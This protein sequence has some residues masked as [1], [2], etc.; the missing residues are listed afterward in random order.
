MKQIILNYLVIFILPFLLG[1]VLRFALR[2]RTKAGLMTAAAALLS[3]AAWTVARNPPVLGSELY[4]LRFFQAA[5]FTTGSLLIG[6]L[7]R[8]RSATDTEK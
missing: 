4:G 8:W 1:G 3:L 5:C 6:L 7:L 2:K